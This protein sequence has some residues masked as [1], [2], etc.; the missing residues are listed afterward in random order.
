MSIYAIS[1]AIRK[2]GYKITDAGAMPLEIKLPL[3]CSL[4]LFVGDDGEYRLEPYFG[5]VTRKTGTILSQA[6]YLILFLSVILPSETNLESVFFALFL[7]ITTASL[8]VCRYVV[9]ETA[10]ARIQ[11]EL[12]KHSMA[13]DYESDAADG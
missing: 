11:P 6:L 2:L 4:R 8:E 9:T 1:S 7:T 12:S 13:N 3:Y 5:F 10:I